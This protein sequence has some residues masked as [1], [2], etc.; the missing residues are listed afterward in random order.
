MIQRLN[1]QL[2]PAEQREKVRSFVRG[3]VS[4]KGLDSIQDAKSF[5]RLTRP[6]RK[7]ISMNPRKAAIRF[8][9][10]QLLKE[11]EIKA[12]AAI[13]KFLI[14]APV[15]SLSGVLVITVFTSP[16]PT[17]GNK[18]QRF[19]CKHN[20]YYCP[21]EPGTFPPLYLFSNSQ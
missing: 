6:I 10:N 16:Y 19:S 7:K 11:G 8:T 18:T 3:V 13:E 15:R 21:N 2:V 14:T 9:Y 4:L 12:S 20:C 1:D 17:Y 5:N